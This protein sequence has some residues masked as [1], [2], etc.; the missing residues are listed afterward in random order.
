MRGSEGSSTA[1]GVSLVRT[2]HQVVDDFPHILDDPISPML[3]T[4]GLIERIRLEPEKH[5]TIAAHG[6]RSHI[7]LRSRYAE[8]ELY[9]ATARGMK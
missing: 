4:E 3:F 9:E 5:R 7:V 1:L 2:V 6:L 8:D